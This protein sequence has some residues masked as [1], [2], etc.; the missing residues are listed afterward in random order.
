[1]AKLGC[2]CGYVMSNSG[3][4]NEV[5]GMLVS[6]KSY[7]T[8]SDYVETVVNDCFAHVQAGKLDEWRRKY[9]DKEHWAVTP[10]AMLQHLIYKRFRGLS[11]DPCR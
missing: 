9:F 11:L 6:D 4:P 3:F 2:Q 5:E 7:D 1:M 8:F 10:G